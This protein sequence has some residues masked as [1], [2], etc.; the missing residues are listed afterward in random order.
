ME[1]MFENVGRRN[2]SFTF[3]FIPK[4]VQ[5]AKSIENELLS[6]YLNE[7]FWMTNASGIVLNQK[8]EVST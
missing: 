3:A 7:D 8:L 5:E 4:S 6:K 2:F 1:L